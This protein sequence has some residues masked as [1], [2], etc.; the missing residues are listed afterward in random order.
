MNS[1][2]HNPNPHS[3]GKV[4]LLF[5]LLFGSVNDKSTVLNENF[6]TLIMNILYVCVNICY[7]FE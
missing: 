4:V 5:C 6:G 3:K 7:I 2:K 1:I